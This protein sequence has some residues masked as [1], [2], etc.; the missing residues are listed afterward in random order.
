MTLDQGIISVLLVT[1]LGLFLWGR[2]RYD[3]VAFLA[4]VTA[5]MLG[6]VPA[7]DMFSGFGHP[8]TITVALVLILSRGLQN[9]GSIDIV[10]K[11][12]LPP[13]KR[14]EAHLGALSGVAGG[15]SAL[16]NNVG[17]LA[18]LMPAALS[19]AA[20][21]KRSAAQ[22]LMP[23]S[24]GSILG[25][26]I[27]LIGTP[28]N[29]IVASFR[30]DF[31]GQPFSMFDFTPVGGLVA[32]AGIIFV[33]VIGWRLIPTARRSA[34]SAAEVIHIEDYVSE[35]R[36]A[37]GSN[38]VGKKLRELDAIAEENDAVILEVLRRGRRLALSGR[39]VEIK[40]SDVFLIQAGPDA[41]EKVLKAM[42]LTPA[43]KREKSGVMLGAADISVME[44]VISTGSPLVGNTAE[45]ARLR[46]R[47]GA[48]LLAVSREGKPI[49]SRLKNFKFRVGDVLLLEGDSDRLP[50]AAA[51]LRCL[52]LAE[53]SV[54]LGKLH[55]T[56]I[57]MLMFIT[58]V[59]AA[60]FG[61][62]PLPA[63]LAVA[64]TGMVLF[65]IVPLR[66]LYETIDW[67]VVVLI[68]AMIPVGG[69]LQSTGA[70]EVLVRNLLDFTSGASP[71]L[72]LV[73]VMVVTMTLSD[74]INNAATAVVMAPIGA[75][76][77]QS[78]GVSP[79]PFLMAV[80]ISASCAFLTPIGHQNNTLIMGPGGYHFSDYWRMGLPL[81]VL[82]IALSVP[83]LLVFWPL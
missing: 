1:V 31:E 7:S 18:L 4:L 8:A 21:A 75:G 66:D 19:S 52:P 35:A 65:N 69:A 29:I 37:R 32:I 47:Y 20:K 2:W 70:T 25:G 81:E 49:R 62:V 41:L 16:M 58:A 46:A 26:L 27:T 24:F 71:V 3:V 61:L 6:L 57:A 59:A 76:L 68:G 83:L 33:A 55:L 45:T 11:Y 53:R 30:E 63:A 48:N 17:A 42:D 78:L 74:V 12:L 77:A 36:A 15:L 40:T 43:T 60:A 22:V 38:A 44:A 73:V 14:P 50:D 56:G 67:P 5:T 80:A 64:A 54:T 28:P 10:A 39:R 23:V 9:A 72:L 34:P 79:D 82:V 51:R 13:L